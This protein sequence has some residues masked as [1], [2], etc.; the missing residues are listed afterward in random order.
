MVLTSIGLFGDVVHSVTTV[1]SSNRGTTIANGMAT[2]MKDIEGALVSWFGLGGLIPDGSSTL[3]DAK[4]D[5]WGVTPRQKGES[6]RSYVHRVFTSSFFA[7]NKKDTSRYELT[8]TGAKEL[9]NWV[10][11][12]PNVYYYSISTEDT[13]SLFY[14]DTLDTFRGQIKLLLDLPAHE[15]IKRRLSV[16]S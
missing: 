13:Y 6:I 14:Y 5:H 12:Q 4:L 1:S 8:T 9:K 7:A 2:T 10:R 3:Y 11:T 15:A 16:A